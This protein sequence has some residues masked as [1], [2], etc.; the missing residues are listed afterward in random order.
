MVS[1]K[2]INTFY[3]F[4]TSLNTHFTA[5]ENKI[6]N[7]TAYQ[8]NYTQLPIPNFAE[9]LSEIHIFI[10]KANLLRLVCD[11]LFLLKIFPVCIN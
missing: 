3:E 9:I 7:F 6:V 10:I 2:N 5:L 4:Q 8:P 1:L 11:N